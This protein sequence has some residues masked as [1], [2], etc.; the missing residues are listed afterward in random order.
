MK[1][2]VESLVEA[3]GKRRIAE[4]A[5]ELG[6]YRERMSD[7]IHGKR[8]LSKSEAKKMVQK[9]PEWR[10]AIIASLLDEDLEYR[11]AYNKIA[12]NDDDEADLDSGDSTAS[13]NLT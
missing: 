5:R 10:E 12:G 6:L 7:L 8:G 1:Y 11:D 4:L 9:K 2:L 3:K 13:G